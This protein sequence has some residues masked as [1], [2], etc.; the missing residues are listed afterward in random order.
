MLL[1]EENVHVDDGDC[2]TCDEYSDFAGTVE[3]EA[4]FRNETAFVVE[5]DREEET[6][7]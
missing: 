7:N 1:I 4:R 6:D 3:I 2:P 5:E